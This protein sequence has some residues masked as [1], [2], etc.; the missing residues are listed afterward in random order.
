M[1]IENV[2][3][4][5]EEA[6]KNGCR[7]VSFLYTSKG[8]GET[9]RYTVALGVRV[10]NAYKRD[11]ALLKQMR[12]KTNP[13]KHAKQ[14]LIESMEKSLKYGI[15][16]NPAFTQ[17]G[18]YI[19]LAKGLKE[20]AKTGDLNLSGFVIQREVVKKGVH[21]EVNHSQVVWEKEQLK[22]KLKS[23][24]FRNFLLKPE[25]I[26]GVKMNGKVLVIHE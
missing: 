22:K 25:N 9:S 24:R 14:Q 20:N 11:I 5:V 4:T 18:T 15:G 26:G 13:Q 19:H 8:S 21:K 7:F 23:G 6:L 2:I 16:N 12:V 17:K 1:N 10:A 3:G